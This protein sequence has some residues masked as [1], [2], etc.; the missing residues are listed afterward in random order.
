V[1][2]MRDVGP[3]QTDPYKNS[4]CDRSR[5]TTWFTPR[6]FST[7]PN[8]QTRRPFWSC[9][10]CASRPGLSLPQTNRVTRL[11]SG[12]PAPSSI[13]VGGPCKSVRCV[14][15]TT[16]PDSAICSPRYLSRFRQ[17][18]GLAQDEPRATA[19]GA[20]ADSFTRAGA[21]KGA[22]T[23]WGPA[24]PVAGRLPQLLLI[25]H[26]SQ[27]HNCRQEGLPNPSS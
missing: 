14:V 5:T 8:T 12:Y 2:V 25:L 11:G 4:I 9:S 17:S 1:D 15:L 23:T 13:Q 18:T 26:G 19:A 22:A 27:W 10:I 20:P 3:R 21:T 6:N 24:D 7:V 16:G